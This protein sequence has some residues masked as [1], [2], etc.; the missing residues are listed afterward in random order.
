MK[1]DEKTGNLYITDGMKGG[2]VNT[3][4][5]Y[6]TNMVVAIMEGRKTKT[7]RVIKPIPTGNVL[8]SLGIIVMEKGTY[9]MW[10]GQTSKTMF[11]N[12][13][14]P[15]GNPGNLLYVREAFW[16]YGRWLAEPVDGSSWKSYIPTDYYCRRGC[17]RPIYAADILPDNQTPFSPMGFGK[18]FGHKDNNFRKAEGLLHWRKMPSIFMPKKMARIILK[19]ISTNPSRLRDITNN[20]ILMEGIHIGTNG[21]AWVDGIE[22]GTLRDAFKCLWDSINKQRGYGWE[23]NPWVWGIKFEVIT[24]RRTHDKKG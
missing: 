18:P 24:G 17:I 22:F 21:L 16:D 20:D 11:H 12:F 15:Y 23:T 3:S 2:I 19:V 13:K 4:I 7:R 14:S 8:H 1:W 10:Q 6:S 9:H 5:I